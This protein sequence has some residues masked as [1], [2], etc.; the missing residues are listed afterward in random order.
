MEINSI[1]IK[2]SSQNLYKDNICVYNIISRGVLSNGRYFQSSNYV[3]E[4]LIRCKN[5]PTF[6]CG[7]TTDIVDTTLFFF[8]VYLKGMKC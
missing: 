1:E 3:V 4:K 7:E 5:I 2:W 6:N 8:C